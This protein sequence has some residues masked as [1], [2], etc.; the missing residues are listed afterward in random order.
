MLVL[1]LMGG[2]IHEHS[3]RGNSRI[4]PSTH[5]AR[6]VSEVSTKVGV[7]QPGDSIDGSG[8]LV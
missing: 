6:N 5:C 4:A 1:L 2:V 8:Q 7:A 3:G